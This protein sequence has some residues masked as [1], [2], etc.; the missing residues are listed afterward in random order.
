[1]RRPPAGAAGDGGAGEGV[2]GDG[3]A[4]LV[5]TLRLARPGFRLV[6]DLDVPAGR[7]FALLGPN[8]AGK[9]TTLQL[10][11]GLLRLREGRVE[12]HGRTLD[13]PASGLHVPP[14][15]R[16][17]GVV[18]QDH[19]LFPHLDARDN[20]AFGPR[21]RG[22]SRAAARRQAEHWLERVG[23]AGLSARRPGELSGGQAQ[24][25][26]LARALATAPRLLLLDEPLAALD[27]GTRASVRADLAHH[28]ADFTGSCVLV[29]HDPL[30]AMVLADRVVVLEQGG[31]VQEGSPVEV[32]R[33]PRTDYVA[34]LVGLNLLS[35]TATAGRVELVDGGRLST[36]EPVQGAVLLAF[37]PAA[38]ALSA[39]RPGAASPR[40]VWPCTV[41][42]LERH[43]DVVRVRLAGPPDVLADVTAGAV[44]E[45]R[46]ALGSQVWASL[47]ATE[48]RAYPA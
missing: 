30:D 5:A 38:V 36:A 34:R 12:L 37:S 2:A 1:M 43:G 16:E 21:S 45:L 48:V 6:L 32:A 33:A 3:V 39:T 25:V 10:L 19:L 20:V 40:N 22:G 24:R 26:A 29:S 8:G 44:A 47:K 14:A 42:G 35:G 31:V 7:T 11:A 18:F 17:V 13:D 4:G 15:A 28:L 9:S 27:A 23:L 41:A 46:L